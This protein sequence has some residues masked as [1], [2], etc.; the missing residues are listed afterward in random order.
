MEKIRC[1]F[2]GEDNRT[3]VLEENGFSGV[4]CH[5][6]ELI[7]VSPRPTLSETLGR[8][9]NDRASHAAGSII[10]DEHSKRLNARHTLNLINSYLRKGSVLEIGAG[11][12]YFLDE[13]RRKGF[14]VYGIEIN[15]IQAQFIRETLN[16]PCESRPIHESDLEGKEFD[17]IYHRNVLSHFHDPIA[18]FRDIHHRLKKEGYLVF[19]TGNLGEVKRQYY[20]LYST[21]E[22]PDHLFFYGRNS[23][24]RLLDS[25]GFHLIQMYEYDIF[26]EL[27]MGRTLRKIRGGYGE[28]ATKSAAKSFGNPSKRSLM[29]ILRKANAY[30]FHFLTYQLGTVWARAGGPK[31]LIVVAHKV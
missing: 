5:T 15:K 16:I 18:E 3:V 9:A 21:L 29:R 14:D 25:T 6:C 1:I 2:C 19:E 8:Y 4:K 26:L 31:T 28:Q 27:L 22:Y 7:Y 30:L 23:L 24:R 13:A 10:R 20:N 12:G 17:F 11:A